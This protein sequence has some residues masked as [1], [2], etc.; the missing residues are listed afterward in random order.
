MSSKRIEYEFTSSNGINTVRGVKYIPEDIKGVLVI[1][2]GMVEHYGRY[3]NF[4]GYMADNGYAVYMHD[5]IG[6]LHSVDND[7]QL[8]FFGSKEGYKVLLRDIKKTVDIAREENPGKK[9][10]LLGHSMGSFYA[11]VYPT[12]YPGTVDGLII[13]G[14]GGPNK[15]AGMGKA[16]IAV[17][18]KFKGEKYRSTMIRNMTFKGYLSRIENPRTPSDWITR[19]EAIVDRYVV[20]PGCT[21]TFTLAGYRDLM[22]ILQIANSEETYRKTDKALPIYIFSGSE[23]PVGGFGLGVMEVFENYKSGG[24]ENVKVKIY[25]EGRHEMLNELNRSEVYGDVLSWMDSVCI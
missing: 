22:D 14:T 6:H 20:D 18:S 1:S 3:E 5:H 17:M 8:G 21:F 4:M 19:D 23:D 9:L 24:F 25:P 11:R 2:H 13:S 12:Y 7:E 16:L 10:V 15:A